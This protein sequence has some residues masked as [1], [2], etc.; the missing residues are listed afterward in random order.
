[1]SDT[2]TSLGCCPSQAAYMVEAFTPGALDGYIVACAA[3]TRAASDYLTDLGYRPFVGS[4]N[5]AIIEQQVTCGRLSW[6]RDR[7]EVILE[8]GAPPA[9][10]IQLATTTRDTAADD[11]DVLEARACKNRG[12]DLL[13]HWGW[14][15]E[16]LR[17]KDHRALAEML[18]LAALRLD[19]ADRERQELADEAEAL[20][21]FAPTVRVCIDV[22]CPG[23]GYPER[24]AD[25]L[26]DLTRIKVYGCLKC[27]YRS[28]ER[29][30]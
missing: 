19:A 30:R 16:G 13:A 9:D 18:A 23:C 5:A 22:D 12:A 24:W 20:W 3:H 25:A 10:V 2:T 27:E 1:M 17:S 11:L 4:P 7:P 21:N 6:Y 8:F 29:D 26:T 14:L 15:S 28:R